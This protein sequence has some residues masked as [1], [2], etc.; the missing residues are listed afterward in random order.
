MK[1][2]LPQKPGWGTKA[3]FVC[4][5]Q[6]TIAE[7][8]LQHGK[9]VR[10]LRDPVVIQRAT[11]EAAKHDERDDS[12]T[13]L[14]V[15]VPCQPHVS[16]PYTI[17]VA[18]LPENASILDLYK[19]L[20]PFGAINRK[21]VHIMKTADEGSC[22]GSGIVEFMDKSAAEQAIA[23]LNG[24]RLPDGHILKVAKKAERCGASEVQIIADNIV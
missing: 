3:A 1:M 6:A 21:G 8:V 22:R 16:S 17:C 10:G 15:A 14:T 19:L 7:H 12:A 20:S 5:K 18:N 23:K 9:V 13:W 2:M 24:M 4:Y 11:R